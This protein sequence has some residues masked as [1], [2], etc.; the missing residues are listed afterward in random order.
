MDRLLL[1][2]QGLENLS[3]H[4]NFNTRAHAHTH[5]KYL[6][7]RLLIIIW[8]LIFLGMERAITTKK[9]GN[10]HVSTVPVTVDTWRE[11]HVYYWPRGHLWRK[12][13]WP[14]VWIHVTIWPRVFYQRGEMATCKNTRGILLATWP[15]GVF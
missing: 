5:I 11:R 7:E 9:T 14:R 6:L 10:R 1:H 13:N 12:N 4:K 3:K 8:T 2:L 15:S